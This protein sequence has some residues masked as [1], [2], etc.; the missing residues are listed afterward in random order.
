MFGIIILNM[1]K[2]V[3]LVGWLLS[4][5]M[6]SETLV[7]ILDETTKKVSIYLSPTIPAMGK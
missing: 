4:Q 3:H 7:Q 5:E 1:I 2:E 6:E